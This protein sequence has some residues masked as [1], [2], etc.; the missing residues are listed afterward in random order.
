MHDNSILHRDIKPENIVMT[1]VNIILYLRMS[2]NYV[3]SGGL[4][5]AKIEGRPIAVH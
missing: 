2:A 1:N 4:Q 5:F 3:I